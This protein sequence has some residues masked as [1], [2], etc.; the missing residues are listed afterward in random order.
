MTEGRFKSKVDTW[1][2]IALLFAPVSTVLVVLVVVSLE[3]TPVPMLA[4]LA[5]ILLLGGALPLWILLQTHYSIV[6]AR[7]VVRCGP[8]K[9]VIPVA[10][11]QSITP[12]RNPL[13][14]PALSLDRLCVTYGSGR[15]VMIS[16]A[17]PE[18]F[19]A[20]LEQQRAER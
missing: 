17:D 15:A 8:F 2:T 1:M 5:L 7:L 14:S 3:P 16:P 12:T 18:G 20:R 10:D 6:D 9:W 11:I 4:I 13:S 19:M